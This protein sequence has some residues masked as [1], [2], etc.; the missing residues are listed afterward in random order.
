[1]RAITASLVPGAANRPDILA[2]VRRTQ[3]DAILQRCPQY[4]FTNVKDRE[5]AIAWTKRFPNPSI[6]G[7][8]AEIEVRQYF[9]LERVKDA[10]DRRRCRPW[11]GQRGA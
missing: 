4:I 11:S 2:E 3:V 5:E 6:D 9:E 8:E 1:M 7:G 10:H